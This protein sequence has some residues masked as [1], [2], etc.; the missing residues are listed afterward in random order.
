MIWKFAVIFIGR[1]HHLIN[2]GGIELFE[3]LLLIYL[4][5]MLCRVQFPFGNRWYLP[6]FLDM[7]N[8]NMN[9]YQLVHPFLRTLFSWVAYLMRQAPD[10]WLRAPFRPRTSVKA[11][12]KNRI[13]FASNH[14]AIISICVDN[15]L[16]GYCVLSL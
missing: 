15:I 5:I 2:Y 16:S 14:P 8:C 13:N 11:K 1:R 4:L 6:F 3:C 7:P 10:Q 12:N 9:I